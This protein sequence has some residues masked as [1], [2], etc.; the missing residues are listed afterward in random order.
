MS[1]EIRTPMH[2]II[3]LIELAMLE[4]LPASARS[5]LVTA[6]TASHTLLTILNDI[7]L[8]S[9]IE[10]DKVTEDVSRI[11]LDKLLVEIRN[12]FFISV[13]HRN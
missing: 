9:K 11:S 2:G 13:I 12:L 5:L 6:Q 4:E 1:H 3:G 8:F 7:L 10:E